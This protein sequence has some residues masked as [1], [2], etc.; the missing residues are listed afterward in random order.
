[1]TPFRISLIFILITIVGGA[2]TLLLEVD[3]TPSEV[4]NSF[5]VSFSSDQNDPPLVTEQKVTSVLEGV[6]SS[7]AGVKEIRSV[8][9]FGGGY[10]TLSFE[11]VNLQ[12]KRLEILTALR[13]A[14]SR[15]PDRM[16]FP[17]IELGEKENVKEPL[18]IYSVTS[19]LPTNEIVEYANQQIIPSMG[20]NPGIKSVALSTDSR[21]IIVLSYSMDQ[22]KSVG[23]TPAILQSKLYE[24][25][26]NEQLGT[27]TSNRETKSIF[28][29]A[30]PEDV[31]DILD[32]QINEKL[33]LGDVA[34]VK[35]DDMRPSYISRLNGKNS[36]LLRLFAHEHVNKPELARILR[37]EVALISSRLPDFLE[38]KLTYDDTEF[39]TRELNKITRRALLSISILSILVLLVYRKFSQLVVLI[40]SVMVSLGIS[41]LIMYLLSVPVHLYTIAG[42]TISFGLVIDNSI[43]VIDH[44]RRKKDLKVIT[45][46]LAATLTTIAALLV[47]FI[48]PAEDR[49]GMGDFALAISIALG[50]SVVVSLLF[51]PAFSKVIGSDK[52]NIQ[53][54]F[55]SKRF[56]VK[57]QQFYFNGTYWLSKYKRI[58]FIGMVLLFG[59]PVY[60]VP[61]SIEG[62]DFYNQT[63]GSDYYQENIR[64]VSD[65]VFGGMLRSFYLNV[66]ESS[67]YRTPEKTRLYVSASLDEGHTITQMNEII[68]NVELYLKEVKG[69]ES[70]RTTIYSGKYAQVVIEFSEETEDGSLPYVL[71]NRLI[72]RSLDWGGV[73]WNVYGVGRGFSN[74][75]GES[76]PSFRI[77]LKGYNYA[78]LGHL[79]EDIAS[80]LLVHPRIKGVNTNDRIS[81]RDATSEQIVL[82]PN[83][84]VNTQDYLASL[85]DIRNAAPSLVPNRYISINNT[86]LPILFKEEEAERFSIFRMLK[87]EGLIPLGLMTNLSREVK[88]SAL[89]REDRQYVRVLT[90]EYYG[91]YRFG[92]EYLKKVLD[93]FVFP[94][95][96]SFE[97]QEFSWNSEKTRR[98]YSMIVLIL[99]FIFVICT[100][101]FESIRLPLNIL[102]IIPLSFIGIFITFSWGGFYF[103]QGGYA[104]FILLAGI[105]V[106]A[107]IFILNETR[108]YRS[109][110]WNRNLVK[111]C[112]RKFLPILLTIV[113]TCLGLVPFLMDGQQEVFWFSFAVGVIGGLLFSVFLVFVIFPVLLMKRTF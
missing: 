88:S 98:Q 63:I 68:R 9:R 3:F 60:L 87:S 38:L 39:I 81:W 53:G 25:I 73:D 28:V 95:G 107:A 77:T 13:Q 14:M 71:K 113:S 49:I 74:A 108:N 85:E 89:Y 55:Q 40:G 93:S 2:S 6:L 70:F 1:M 7:V 103:D 26:F 112:S 102:M 54:S 35:I 8:S 66:F 17:T 105:V 78:D 84:Q 65:K 12:S 30:V 23:L 5:I 21:P 83:G 110:D 18:L 34:S 64:P 96:Y 22:L 16:P 42:L 86:R 76:L 56:H 82:S 72:Q 75:S 31:S 41:G 58:I 43:M 52:K 47:I 46:L 62:A 61:K 97:K 100:A 45:A 20:L 104:A 109:N 36:V 67:G 101:T 15:L 10:I 106:N 19:V 111:A 44:F 90:F 27:I 69:L 80:K 79:A 24:S 29:S 92:D 59:L 57:I 99:I 32:I 48:L 4:S 33:K 11:Q 51:T 37:S 91:S 94:P 50:T